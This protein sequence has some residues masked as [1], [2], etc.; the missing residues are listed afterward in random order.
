[1]IFCYKNNI[2][3]GIII[4]LNDILG[5]AVPYT[6][7]HVSDFVF[8]IIV[9]LV[10]LIIAR[11]LVSIFKRTLKR[12]KIPELA[13]SFLVQFLSALLYVAVLL[14]VFT[15][16]GITVSSIILGLSAVIGLILGF[17]MQDTLT[18]LGAGIW[19]AVLEPFKENDFITV[20]GQTG[21]VRQV[22]L[23]S[24][25]L[26]TTDNIYIMIPNKMVWNSPIVNMSHFP[27]RR[28]DLTMTFNLLGN[29]D[30]TIKTVLEVLNK[31]PEILQTPEPKIF[32]SNLTE[33]AA[34]LQIRFWVNAS[35]INTISTALKEDLLR[36]FDVKK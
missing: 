14:A 29:V 7:W 20:S 26:V 18:N 32:I 12:S 17:G 10:A 24:V 21:Y 5:T 4:A 27:V 34:D 15:T 9:L 16:L 3:G 8:A 13:A 11:I 19:L 1:M 23:M 28:F 22:G 35:S 33:G 31:N 30:N 25:E 2:Y 6:Q 36:E